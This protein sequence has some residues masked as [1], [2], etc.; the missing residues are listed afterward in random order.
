M[1]KAK[2]YVNYKPSVLDPKAEVIKN[3]LSRLGQTNVK[4]VTVGKYF[5]VLLEGNRDALTNK[6]MPYA[7]RCWPTSTWSL[8]LLA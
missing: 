3:T 5:E 4:D 7:I 8:S 6:L 2:I 1:F